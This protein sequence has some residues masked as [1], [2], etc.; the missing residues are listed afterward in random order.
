MAANGANGTVDLRGEFI[1]GLDNGRGVDTGRT[2]ASW[3]AQLFQDHTHYGSRS[4]IMLTNTGGQIIYNDGSFDTLLG[5]DCWNCGSPVYPGV[6]L[7][8]WASSSGAGSET[9][10]RN[11][12]LLACMKR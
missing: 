3:Q 12:S 9:R 7:S 8:P 2:L 11:L 5:T 10:P 4:A 6:L 1:R